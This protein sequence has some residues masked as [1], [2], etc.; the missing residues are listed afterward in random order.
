MHK[1]QLSSAIH[2]PHN[3]R[4]MSP[5]VLCVHTQKQRDMNMQKN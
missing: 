3:E 2:R 1:L 4:N 5:L